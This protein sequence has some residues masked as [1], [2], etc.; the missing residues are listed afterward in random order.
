LGGPLC[1][2]SRAASFE[3]AATLWD[4]QPLTWAECGRKPR[5]EE[6][7]GDDWRTYYEGVCDGVT[8]CPECAARVKAPYCSGAKD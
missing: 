2:A 5:P 8:L 6:N 1:C 3:R 4:D 7:A